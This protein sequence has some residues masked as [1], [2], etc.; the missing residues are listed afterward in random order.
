MAHSDDTRRA[1]HAVCTNESM[2]A[3]GSQLMV[4][5]WGA[6]HA[7]E[8]MGVLALALHDTRDG[9]AGGAVVLAN[10]RARHGG[11]RDRKQ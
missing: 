8:H 3:S 9:R 11:E 6:H 2:Q 4:A 7:E 1:R 5:V 10:R